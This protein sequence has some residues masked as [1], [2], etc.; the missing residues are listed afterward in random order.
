MPTIYTVKSSSCDCKGENDNTDGADENQCRVRWRT[1]ELQKQMINSQSIWCTRTRYPQAYNKKFCCLLPM[2]R[3]CSLERRAAKNQWEIEALSDEQ[4]R[5]HIQTA[6][7]IVQ[8][9]QPSKYII[10]HLCCVISAFDMT[11]FAT[12][13]RLSKLLQH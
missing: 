1:S 11:H 4:L 13:L 2:L 10:L 8:K 5:T 9:V 7:I 6:S 12:R 3:G